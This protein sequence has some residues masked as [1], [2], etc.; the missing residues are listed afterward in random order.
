MGEP[1][2]IIR[3]A[4]QSVIAEVRARASASRSGAC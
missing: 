1:S 2:P 4:S 3:P